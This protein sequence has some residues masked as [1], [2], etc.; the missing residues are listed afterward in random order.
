MKDYLGGVYGFTFVL[1]ILWQGLLLIGEIIS[2]GDS[3]MVGSA[4]ATLVFIELL[5][6]L[7][8]IIP[9]LIWGTILSL[10]GAIPYIVYKYLTRPK[11][12]T[13]TN[14][15]TFTLPHEKN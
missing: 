6:P 1:M 3:G 10:V 9:T 15:S 14:S 12:E 5:A 13:H 8:A 2:L 4:I 7:R 11:Y